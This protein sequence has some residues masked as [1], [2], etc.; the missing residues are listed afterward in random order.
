M[1]RAMNARD[2]GTMTITVVGGELRWLLE[3]QDDGGPRRVPLPAGRTVLGGQ[4]GADIVIRD[5]TVS[6]AHC[7]LTP[8]GRGLRIEDLG[9]KN[10][11][12]VGG[13][14]VQAARGEPGVTVVVGRSA[15]TC[16]AA[17]EDDADADAEPLAGVAGGCL[18]MRRLAAQ[19][20]RLA[21]SGAPVLVSGETG[22]GKE[23]VARALHAEGPRA[24]RPF[25][26][27]NVAAL[28]RELVESE[29]FG[30][31]RGAFTGAVERRVGA[32]AE[33]E[34]GTLFLDEVGD[35]PLEAQPKLLRALDGYEV[36]RV[37]ARG[38]G[39]KPNVRVVAATHVKLEERVARGGFREDLY[40]R[41]AVFVVRIP[42]L[43][44]RR[45]DVAAIASA[46]LRASSGELGPR[47]LTSS[48]VA[49]LVRHDWPGN[50]RQLRNVL[51][52]AA[53]VAGARRSIEA[54]D[55]DR[56][57]GEMGDA[58]YVRAEV[59]PQIARAM[60]RDNRGN[61]S[62]A[63]RAAGMPRTS[64]RKVLFGG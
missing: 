52:R 53:D 17:G 55:V 56:A 12:F 27:V 15:I 46:V 37:G 2:S 1:D 48:A 42:P 25:V 60:L 64:F 35:L 59:T 40:H 36:R 22:S 19:V 16:V 47:L 6:G 30:H 21:A 43:R 24:A 13:A 14:R 57:L 39:R 3:V 41:L 51:L 50:V 9:S 8:E 61:L 63:A 18:A 32:F 4:E 45:G 29:M 11:T 58:S 62:A 28:P 23:L 49:R 31:E 38:S 34:D 7:A 26:P 54:A 44:E 10:G 33:A 20:R 5:R